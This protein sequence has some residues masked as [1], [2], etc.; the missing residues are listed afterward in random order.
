MSHFLMFC[1]GVVL[2]FGVSFYLKD[3]L[4]LDIKFDRDGIKTKKVVYTEDIGENGKD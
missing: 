2:G 4:H 1:F 3:R